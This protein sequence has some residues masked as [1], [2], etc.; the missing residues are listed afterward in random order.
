MDK[1]LKLV[2]DLDDK[3]FN[4]AIKRIQD[5][6]SQI[7][8]QPQLQAQQR[9][10]SQRMQQLGLGALPGA[11]TDRQME[12]SK[13]KSK[14]EYD[15]LFRDTVNNMSIIKR[16][17]MDLNKQLDVGLVTE[18]KRLKIRE[19]L[20]ELQREE[21][22]ATGELK[23]MV[24]PSD[25]GAASNKQ[26]GSRLAGA[27]GL[28][29]GGG[30]IYGDMG[31]LPIEAAEA[32]GSAV[33]TLVGQQLKEIADPYKQSFLPER[34]KAIEAARKA[35]KAGRV[36]DSMVNIAGT[37]AAG[38]GIA[39]VIAAGAL[40]GGTAL[41]GGAG[42]AAMFGSS[43]Q[44]SLT[45][46]NAG[47]Y[48]QLSSADLADL[49]QRSMKA[50]EEANPLKKLGAEYNAQNYQ[51][52]LGIQRGLGL[53]DRGFMGSGGFLQG[54]MGY[55]GHM[56]FTEEQVTQMQQGILGAG[57]SARMGR[58][59]GFG[60]ELQKNLGLTN[61]PQMLGGLSRSLGGAEQTKEASIRVIS[62]AFKAGLNDSELVDLLRS[63][64]QTTSEY[65]AR[66]GSTTQGDVGRISSQFGKGMLENSGAGVE[67]AKTAYEAYQ[68]LSGQT[69][70]PFSN[71]QKAA[72]LR[73]P[74]LRS[75]TSG[76]EDGAVIFEKLKQIP[77]EQ[78]TE[79]HPAVQ[80][81]VYQYNSNLGPGQKPI[82]ASD[83]I[84]AQLSTISAGGSIAGGF[85]KNLAAVNRWKGANPGMDIGQAP[86]NIQQA[87]RMM[88]LEATTQGL[89][90]APELTSA[91]SIR[92]YGAQFLNAG[93]EQYG[94]S[95]ALKTTTRMGDQIT[96]NVAASQQ[97]LIENFEKFGSSLVPTANNLDDL[98]KRLILLGQVAA[99]IASGKNPDKGA[100]GKAASL[101]GQP[102]ANS[103]SANKGAVGSW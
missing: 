29:G 89:G 94:P 13:Q 71:M 70:G 39:G 24:G 58:G 63:F 101:M 6:L 95:E 57:G 54:N 98:T 41:M 28:I 47:A 32:A 12:Q 8:S 25:T 14:Q 99:D 48:E 69:G 45:S 100:L 77:Q 35:W 92:A 17:Q 79:T 31:R 9:Q 87:A 93:A 74:I 1:K 43:K 64:T 75:L 42:L 18:E 19:R 78:L 21:I 20:K 26:L 16:E 3:S 59:A 97:V 62:E 86:A 80:A 40:T 50:Q 23:A 44:R 27:A 88:S 56:Q 61:A 85:S 38:V 76:G 82:T 65:V 52:N 33:S 96:A 66:S 22:R 83:I 55:S 73:N 68:R 7:N 84:A 2:L 91:Q 51:R 10:I 67:G 49:T 103:S 81:A 34:S 30:K 72:M 4:N 11:P 53:S 15:K 37:I 46:G 102:Q 90:S 36:E 60:L 5:Q